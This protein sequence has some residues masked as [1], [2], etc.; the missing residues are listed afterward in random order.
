M[1]KN[2]LADLIE[3]RFTPFAFKCDCDGSHMDCAEVR[4]S[5]SGWAQRDTVARIAKFIRETADETI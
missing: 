3:D 5:A 2:E 4:H 1:N